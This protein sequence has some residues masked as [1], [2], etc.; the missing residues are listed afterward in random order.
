MG[1][2]PTNGQADVHA[3]Y[4]LKLN[5][6]HSL[7]FGADFFNITNQKTLQRID[8]FQDRSFQVLNADFQKPTQ[9]TGLNPLSGFQEPFSARLFAKWVF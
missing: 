7:H 9:G 1:R 8:Q 5:E 2:T 4:A 3:D 6:K